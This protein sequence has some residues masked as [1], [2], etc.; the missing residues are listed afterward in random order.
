MMD[1]I[2]LIPLLPGLGALLNG[3]VGVRYF[4]KSMSALVAC[5]SM[6]AALL[7]SLAAFVDLLGLSPDAREHT[8]TL[9]AWLP[10]MGLAT[11]HGIGTFEAPWAFRLDPL[12][13]LMILVVTGIGFLIH[14]YSTAYMRDEPRGGYA[15]YFS[16][17]NLFCFFMLMLVLGSNFLV[18]FV[19][20]E[21][22]GLCSYLLIGYWYEKKSASDAGKKAFIVNRIG[23]LGF[24]LGIFLVYFTFGTL[25][26]RAVANAAAAMPVETAAFGV[27]STICLLLFIGATGKSA[28]IPLH[29]WLPDAMEGPTPVSALIH[30]ATMVT[31]GV[32]MV[33]RNA[34]LFSHAPMMMEVVAIVGV[35]TA[36]M[37]ASIGLVQYDIKRV[38]AYSTVSQLGYMFLAM[39]VGAFAA[40]AFHLMTHAFFK[41]LLFLC[42]GAVIHAV[43]GEQDMRRMGGLKPYMPVTF[44]TMMVGTL[45]IAGIPPLAGF[46]SKDEILLATFLSNK[47]IWTLAAMTALMTAFYMFRLMSLTFFGTYRGPAWTAHHAVPAHA[48]PPVAGVADV[49]HGPAHGEWHG[50]HEAPKAMTVPLMV[51]AVGAVVAGFVGVPAVLGGGNAIEHFLEPSFTSSAGAGHAETDEARLKSGTTTQ[52]EGQGASG[53]AVHMSTAGELALMALSVAIA[54][55]GIM[56]AWRVYVRRPEISEALAQRFA[57]PHRVLSNKYYV[58][59]LYDATAV[60]GTLASSRGLWKFDSGVVDGAVNGSGWFTVISSWISHVIDKYVVDGLVNLVGSVMEDS[61]FAFRRLQTGL[62]QNYA[63]LM[64]LGVFAFVSLYLFWR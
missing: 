62:V 51:L 39:G 41:A 63:L 28:Q 16:Y 59:E 50:P 54:L 2:W 35:L 7:L 21:G 29:V 33:G 6:A 10:P 30:A 52:A 57:G 26:F 58:D 27:L 45:A 31:A 15:R 12:S 43:A 11:E 38:L 56:T 47:V 64:L 1:L 5:A 19:G 40:G 60:S 48:G 36:L 46:F 34:V 44:R 25:D 13:G 18:M 32:Y 14:V 22:V 3:V 42:S 61:S 53:E 8:V 24:I 17:L 55:A 23:D 20:W 4:N 49:A 9:A 37:A